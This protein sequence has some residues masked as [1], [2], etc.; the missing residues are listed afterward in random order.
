LLSSCKKSFELRLH[1]AYLNLSELFFL[2]INEKENCEGFLLWS[3]FSLG[4]PL[5]VLVSH[6]SAATFQSLLNTLFIEF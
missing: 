4:L 5:T 1:L 2:F 6:Y 3:D